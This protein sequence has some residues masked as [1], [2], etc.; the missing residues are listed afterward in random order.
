MK[1]L[2]RRSSYDLIRVLATIGVIAIH[3]D[4][5]TSS[6]T[7]YLGGI[8]WW[9]TTFIHSMSSISVPLFAMLSGALILTR[10][11]LSYEYISQKAKTF[12]FILITWTCLYA[13]WNNYWLGEPISIAILLNNLFTTQVGHLYYLEIAI[14]L[15]LLAPGMKWCLD[16]LNHKQQRLLLAMLSL[17]AITYE[18]ASFVLFRTYNNTNVLLIS[19]P[20]LV[21]FGWGHYV[22]KVRI[23]TKALSALLLFIVSLTL[24][25]ALGVYANTLAW[26]L[27]QRLLWTPSGGNFIWEP[28]APHTLLLALSGF[29]FLNNLGI[30]MSKA[31]NGWF[32]RILEFLAPTCL[33]IFLIHPMI[34]VLVD[35]YLHM[36]IH[37]ITYSLY[38]YYVQ[39]IT[40]VFVISLIIVILAS[41]IPVLRKV[42]GYE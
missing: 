38:L 28:F 4:A 7:N 27:G 6:K 42:I 14:G 34:I 23:N 9:F 17:F 3:T 22:Q 21:F 29:V 35:H 2:Q 16:K 19:L 33:G 37:L 1:K 15:Y 8:S 30:K 31:R 13:L 41:R 20:F 10:N 32:A 40:L 18:I 12:L 24:L 36:S 39:K 25:I 11:K 5:I 26:N